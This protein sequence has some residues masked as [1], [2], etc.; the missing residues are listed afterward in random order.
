ME[1]LRLFRRRRSFA[2][3]A[4]LAVAVL[5]SSSAEAATARPVVAASAGK[6]VLFSR[7]CANRSYKPTLFVIACADARTTFKVKEY[8]TWGAENA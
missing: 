8:A 6:P 5:V 7:Q 4:V 3:V 1:S 2:L